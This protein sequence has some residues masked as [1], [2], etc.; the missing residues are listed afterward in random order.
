MSEIQKIQD[1]E[2]DWLKEFKSNLFEDIDL[3]DLVYFI[4]FRLR[5]LFKLW[6]SESSPKELKVY[7]NFEEKI[8]HLDLNKLDKEIEEYLKN[9]DNE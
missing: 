3:C 4:R 1:I 6:K 5:N 9:I 8:Y 7:D 2:K